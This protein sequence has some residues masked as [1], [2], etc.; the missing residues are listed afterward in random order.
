LPNTYVFPSEQCPGQPLSLGYPQ[1]EMKRLG[2]RDKTTLHGIR[3]SFSD[4]AREN[5]TFAPDAIE[6]A[7]AHKVGDATQQAYNRSDLFRAR[8][9]LADA[10]AAHCLSRPI[11]RRWVIPGALPAASV[12]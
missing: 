2:W 5:L 9:D 4:F 12:A 8:L 1:L 3:S 6:I 7:L 10:W 11:D